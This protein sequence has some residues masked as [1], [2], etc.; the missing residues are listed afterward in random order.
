MGKK[1]GYQIKSTTS[2]IKNIISLL[3]EWNISIPTK[4]K[5]RLNSDNFVKIIDFLSMFNKHMFNTQTYLR[6]YSRK[7][8]LT[9]LLM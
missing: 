9:L 1:N 7:M 4:P 2:A 5:V 6:N 3:R 8:S